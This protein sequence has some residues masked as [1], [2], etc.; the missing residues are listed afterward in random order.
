MRACKHFRFSI[1]DETDIIQSNGYPWNAWI[2]VWEGDKQI[3][4]S[5]RSGLFW[6]Y[7]EH[8][9][10]QEECRKQVRITKREVKSILNFIR[11]RWE[12]LNHE[13]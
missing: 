5:F 6:D 4:S 9:L 13:H 10:L 11:K 3:Y 7:L 12:E 1:G 2:V 8:L